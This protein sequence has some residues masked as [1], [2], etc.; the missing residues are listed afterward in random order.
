[1]L[2]LAEVDANDRI[3]AQLAFDV[4]DMDSAFEELDSRYVAGEAAAYAH[5]WS[6]VTE[7]FVA[8]NRHELPELTP[9]WVNIDHRRGAAFA[10]GDMAAYMNDLWDD[11]RD[12]KVCIAVVHRLSS[13]GVVLTAAAHGTSQQGFEA[14]WRE[15]ILGTVD[16]ELLCRVEIF[17]ET[18]V[19]AALARFDELSRSRP[20]L[21][22]AATRNCVLIAEAFNRR[23]GDAIFARAND[24]G[25][26]EDRRKGLQSILDGPERRKVIDA[27]L[28]T[29]PS[30]WRLEIEPIAVRGSRLS[31]TRD[32]YRD[33]GD[34]NGTIA[35]ELLHL[36]EVDS[37]GLMQHTVSFDPDDIDAALAE[38]DTHYLAGEAAAHAQTWSL[39]TG[40]YDGFNRRDL[41]A[42]TPDWV[43]IDHRSGA[44]F[45][46]GDMI[47]YIEAAW[48]DSPDTRIYIAAVHRLSDVG[49]VVTHVAQ[50]IS[51]GGFDAE[52]RDINILTVDGTLVNRSELFDA[53]DLAA[54][55]ARFDELTAP[56]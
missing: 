47:P 31:L 18:D 52:W 13:L 41:A 20:A 15:I 12:F 5:T 6:V 55:L 28:K 44:A 29:V 7:A 26:Y 40:A 4:D 56:D 36:M 24:D 25:H 39:I 8:I 22:N 3:T 14:Q 32:S 42:T 50:G 2:I 23:D 37:A 54:A 30:T 53:S 19:D 1:M 35:V 33:V 21:E 9:D 17:D 34:P 45:A 16:G 46:S 27:T 48:D 38:L 11:T 51:Q 43:S 10:T 49:A